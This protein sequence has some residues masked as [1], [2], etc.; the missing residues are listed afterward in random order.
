MK[1]IGTLEVL[2]LILALDQEVEGVGYLL[3]ERWKG[4]RLMISDYDIVGTMFL[5]VSPRS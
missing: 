3:I 1:N 4:S 2:S 5:E